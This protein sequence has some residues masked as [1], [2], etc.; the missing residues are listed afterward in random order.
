MLEDLKRGLLFDM[1]ELDGDLK[2]IEYVDTTY[3][4]R[5]LGGGFPAGELGCGRA[6]KPE[7]VP[8]KVQWGGPKRGRVP[9]TLQGR[10][11]MLVNARFKDIIERFEPG[12]HQFLPLTLLWK[13]DTVAQDMYFFNICSR[14]D[15]VDRIATTA[16]FGSEIMWRPETGT[17]VF[18]PAQMGNH[19]IWID[20]HIYYGWFVSDQ[21]HD[22]LVGAKIT[23][24][25]F[26]KWQTSGEA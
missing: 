3:D 6:V 7:F 8:T 14:L 4:Q 26:R 17:I 9:E 13:D 2:K 12:L 25:G 10:G 24:I 11:M 20:K 16:E 19:H 1:R 18:S 22:A 21:L 5:S 15:T 23:G